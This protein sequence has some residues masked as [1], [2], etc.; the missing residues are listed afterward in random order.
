GQPAGAVGHHRLTVSLPQ[1]LPLNPEH[2]YVLVVA[3]PAHAAS[4]VTEDGNTAAFRTYSIGVVTH[5]GIQPPPWRRGG[6]WELRM[7]DSLR[8]EGY[9]AVIAY[10]W[11]PSSGRPGAAAR[12][13]PRLAQAVLNAASQFPTN[14]PVDLHF[15]GHSEGTVVNSL[16]ILQL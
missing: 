5:G 6:P 1:G 9:D 12:Q 15:I 7:A 10:N 8:N 13:G 11:V 2:P 16:A 14:A 3:D 4:G